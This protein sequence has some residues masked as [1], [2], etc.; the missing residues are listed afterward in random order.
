MP[1]FDRG[2][3]PSAAGG[4]FF[5]EPAVSINEVYQLKD[6]A[7]GLRGLSSADSLECYMV[8]AVL[9]LIKGRER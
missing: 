6:Y 2:E 9:V 8:F 3:F 7:A 1:G 5:A 4:G